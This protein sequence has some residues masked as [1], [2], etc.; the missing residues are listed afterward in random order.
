MIQN[1]SDHAA[2]ERTFLAWIRTA[3]AV[4]AFG[5]LVAKF[6]LFLAFAARSFERGAGPPRMAH[7]SGFGDLAGLL[8]IAAGTFMVIV[9]AMRFVRTGRAI[10]SPQRHVSGARADLLLAALMLVLGIAMMLYLAETLIA[11]L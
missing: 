7:M 2:N 11:S 4:M 3:I 6:N 9:A 8:L 1:Y 5:F 10:D